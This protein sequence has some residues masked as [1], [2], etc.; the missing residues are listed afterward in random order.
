MCHPYLRSRVRGLRV[1]VYSFRQQVYKLGL[2]VHCSPEFLAY[3]WSRA[4]QNESRDEVG[5]HLGPQEPNLRGFRA[6][7]SEFRVLIERAH[8]FYWRPP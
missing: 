4:P 3:F 5:K 7:G 6:E 8:K 2:G 1:G